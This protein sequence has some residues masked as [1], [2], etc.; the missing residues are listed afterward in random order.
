MMTSS[1]AL[2]L[3]IRY[4]FPTCKH[5][6]HFNLPPLKNCSLHA[7]SYMYIL[8]CTVTFQICC[9]FFAYFLG[10]PFK[11]KVPAAPLNEFRG[12]LLWNHLTEMSAYPASAQGDVCLE[13]LR[14]DSWVSRAAL[15]GMLATSSGPQEKHEDL[16]VHESRFVG[17]FDPQQLDEIKWQHNSNGKNILPRSPEAIK[18]GKMMNRDKEPHISREDCPQT[19]LRGRIFMD[20]EPSTTMVNG[21]LTNFPELSFV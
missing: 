21:W 10:I 12:F 5:L 20:A 8:W 7:L 14:C 19:P 13:V 16:K 2:L 6:L 11:K 1:L 3:Q 4:R 9:P 15:P 17:D 18:I